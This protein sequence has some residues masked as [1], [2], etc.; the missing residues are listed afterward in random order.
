MKKYPGSH[1]PE[2][3]TKEVSEDVVMVQISTVDRMLVTASCSLL[4]TMDLDIAGS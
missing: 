3:Y 2:V 4:G 1:G